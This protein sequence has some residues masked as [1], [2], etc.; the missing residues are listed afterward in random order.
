M[1]EHAKNNFCR[2]GNTLEISFFCVVTIINALLDNHRDRQKMFTTGFLHYSNN[3]N[4]LWSN[5]TVFLSKT[6]K[7]WFFWKLTRFIPLIE[8][9]CS[10]LVIVFTSTCNM[11]LQSSCYLIK[12]TI[13]WPQRTK[14][15]DSVRSYLIF[16]CCFFLI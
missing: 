8:T 14:N 12:W 16:C 10:L 15:R 9:H 6:L 13:Y 5:I 4:L 3:R 1:L 7:Q 11:T 2:C